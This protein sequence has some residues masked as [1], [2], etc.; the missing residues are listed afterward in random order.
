MTV[1]VT[2]SGRTISRIVGYSEV[3]GRQIPLRQSVVAVEG[4]RFNDSE[5]ADHLVE[6]AKAGERGLAYEEDDEAVAEED[7][8]APAVASVEDDREP[9]EGYANL[10]SA[11]ARQRYE[12]EEDES[13]KSKILEY[14]ASHNNRAWAQHARESEAS[15]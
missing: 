15:L 4:M 13:I 12:S 5:M 8:P 2:E 6:K 11:E 10:N 1:V 3:M 14:E 9:V 7:E